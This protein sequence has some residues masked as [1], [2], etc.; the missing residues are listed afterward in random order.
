MSHDCVI[1]CIYIYASLLLNSFIILINVAQNSAQNVGGQ[2]PR[3]TDQN[4]NSY[5][6]YARLLVQITLRSSPRQAACSVVKTSSQCS[7][8]ALS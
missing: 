1:Y 4:L 5:L 2:E 6:C 3:Y 7:H 8:R